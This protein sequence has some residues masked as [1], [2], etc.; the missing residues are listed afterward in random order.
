[1]HLRLVSNV[2]KTCRKPGFRQ[3]LIEI[4]LMEF[5]Q[6]QRLPVKITTLVGGEIH[7]TRSTEPMQV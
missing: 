3:V 7:C 2:L 4:D 1:M 6:R 5:G